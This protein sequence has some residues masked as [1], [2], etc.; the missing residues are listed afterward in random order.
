MRTKLDR[1]TITGAD[2]SIPSAILAD[3]SDEFPF[4]EWGI[5]VH[6][7]AYEAS[8]KEMYAHRFPSR[9]WIDVLETIASV[10]KMQL[11]LHMCGPWVR[12]ILMGK[13]DFP[14]NILDMFQRV[15]LNFHAGSAKCDAEKCSEVLHKFNRQW[16]FQIDGVLGNRHLLSLYDLANP[17]DCVPLFDVSGGAGVLPNEWPRPMYTRQE[18]PYQYVYHGYAGGLGPHNLAEELPKIIEAAKG[19]QIWIDME[20]HVR[21]ER[22]KQFD[23]LKVRKC[24]EIAEP[25]IKE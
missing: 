14:P 7:V 16:I 11:S 20:T 23:L 13:Q 2:D 10:R 17:P 9:R 24:L 12:S 15:Q 18:A 21:S 5:L 4:V 1:V 3:L 6:K 22:D 25:F 8:E 19:T